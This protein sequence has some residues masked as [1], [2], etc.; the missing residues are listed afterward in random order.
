VH[1]RK[2]FKATILANATSVLF[3]HNYTSGSTETSIDIEIINRLCKA[4]GISEIYILD[5]LIITN[6]YYLS[7]RQKGIM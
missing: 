2:V 1:P 6:N 4:G 5:H 7:L 3:M